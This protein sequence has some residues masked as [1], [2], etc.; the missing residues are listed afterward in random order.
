MNLPF[1]RKPYQLNTL[2]QAIEAA[3]S[4]RCAMERAG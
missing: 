4:M 2:G 1:L 3:L